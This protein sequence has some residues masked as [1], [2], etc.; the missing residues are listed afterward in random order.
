MGLGQIGWVDFLP[1]DAASFSIGTCECVGRF[2]D[3]GTR[4]ALSQYVVIDVPPCVGTIP[5]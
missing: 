2:S 4:N 1:L 3:E 5:P